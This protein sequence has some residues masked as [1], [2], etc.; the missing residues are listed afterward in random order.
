MLIEDMKLNCNLLLRDFLEM[1]DGR[2]LDGVL[3]QEVQLML[4]IAP[5]TMDDKNMFDEYTKI[6]KLVYP[7][8][9]WLPGTS[10]GGG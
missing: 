3:E 7:R 1:G 5:P 4:N 10:A 8:L 9:E 6:R 2:A